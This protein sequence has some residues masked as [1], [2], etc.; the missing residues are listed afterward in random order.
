MPTF[1][2]FHCAV[3]LFRPA[4]Y[5][6]SS[7]AVQY[8]KGRYAGKFAGTIGD[9]GAYSFNGNKIITTGG[10]G[11]V[12]AKDP[13][14]VSRTELGGTG[15]IKDRYIDPLTDTESE[16]TWDNFVVHNKYSWYYRNKKFQIGLKIR[17]CG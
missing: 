14:F 16:Q 17:G 13:I 4:I 5:N 11:A 12:T 3:P 9:F 15:D 6:P 7:L 1:F 8:T 2:L 10:G